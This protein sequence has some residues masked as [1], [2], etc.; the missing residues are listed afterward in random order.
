M[1]YVMVPQELRADFAT[2]LKSFG[3]DRNFET[4]I[5]PGPNTNQVAIQLLNEQLLLSADNP[6]PD[7]REYHIALMQRDKNKPVPQSE[8]ENYWTELR[9]RATSLPG[10]GQWVDQT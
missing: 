8:I 9:R 4:L 2:A 1:A 5:V 6:F 7:P 3:D 10:I